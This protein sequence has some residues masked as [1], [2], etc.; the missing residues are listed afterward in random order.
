MQLKAKRGLG[1]ADRRQEAYNKVLALLN[2]FASFC[3][4][5]SLMEEDESEGR[6]SLQAILSIKAPSTILKHVGPVRTFCEWLVKTN[7]HPPF[8]E[9]S[10]WSFV[11]CVLKGH[12]V[13]LSLAR[14]ES[15]TQGFS[16]LP[17]RGHQRPSTLPRAW[18][19]SARGCARRACTS[20][21]PGAERS[22]SY[23]SLIS[24][25]GAPRW[26]APGS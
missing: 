11:P 14:A 15:A 25:R 22:F 16:K 21:M 12:Q 5:Y 4:L 23:I 1:S 17:C 19:A 26:R 6:D 20:P 10:V 24:G 7:S 18:A 9:K 2:A 13:E 8:G 3:D